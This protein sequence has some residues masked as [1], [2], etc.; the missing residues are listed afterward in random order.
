MDYDKDVHYL[1][2][3]FLKPPF[4]LLSADDMSAPNVKEGLQAAGSNSILPKEHG[5]KSYPLPFV[6]NSEKEVR[7]SFGFRL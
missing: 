2:C 4:S 3:S 5:T 6:K 1:H 7:R